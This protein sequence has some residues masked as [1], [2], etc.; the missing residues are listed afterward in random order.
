MKLEYADLLS[1]DSIFI[2]GLGH[3]HSPH[4]RDLKPSIGIGNFRYK[5]FLN[6]FAW[7]KEQFLKYAK[8]ISLRGLSAFE[9]KENLEVFDVMTIIPVTREMLH[10]AASFF[11]DEKIQW[12]E[13]HHCFTTTDMD[14]NIIGKID[15]NNFK[16]LS[17]VVL[18]L[19]YIGLDK[20]KAPAKFTSDLA[21]SRWEAAQEFLKKQSQQ[22]VEEKAEYQL[23]NIISKLCAIHNSYNLL[24]IFD[25]TVFQLYD[26]FFQCCYL[27]SVD[28]NERIFTIHGGEKFEMDDWLKTIN[29]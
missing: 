27:R 21:K 20:D 12:D 6:F 7:D 22:P 1:G 23:G 13:R 9:G 26:Q 4:L 2:E 24:N 10:K 14:G 17:N 29:K 16:E 25:L 8:V 15:R 11:V 19:N 3:V 28:I 5:L 18:Q